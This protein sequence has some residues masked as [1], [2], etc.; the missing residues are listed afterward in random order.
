M[1]KLYTGLV[2]VTMLA[3]TLWA[4]L[5]VPVW[6]VPTEVLH[7][8]WFVATLFDTYFAFAWFWLWLA[9][10][11]PSWAARVGWGVAIAALGNLAMAAY[12]LLA[13][14]KSRTDPVFSQARSRD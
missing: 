2:L 14:R 6:A 1:L 13:L 11:E 10:R 4:S 12:V 3:V 8:P 7:H 5:Q 9:W